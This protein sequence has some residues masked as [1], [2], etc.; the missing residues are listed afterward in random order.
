MTMLP[1]LCVCEKLVFMGV[2][3]L[4]WEKISYF[5][6]IMSTLD[7]TDFHPREGSGCLLMSNLHPV[8]G[9]LDLNIGLK[10]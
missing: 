5:T 7:W 8:S 2:F 1:I 4:R 10:S 9:H 6:R 3:W